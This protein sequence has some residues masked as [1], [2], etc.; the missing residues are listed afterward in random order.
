MKV[1]EMNREQLRDHMRASREVR[2]FDEYKPEWKRAIDLYRETGNKFD[3]DCSGCR[4][5][6]VEWLE[7]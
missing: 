2:I 3:A 5:R 7:R 4:K 6:L 1:A